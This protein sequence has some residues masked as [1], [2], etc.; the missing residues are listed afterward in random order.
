MEDRASISVV[1]V[2]LD[3]MLFQG[4]VRLVV[5]RGQDGMMHWHLDILLLSCIVPVLLY[6]CSYCFDTV[7]FDNG[8]VMARLFWLSVGLLLLY[9][10][11]C[12]L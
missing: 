9:R 6:C 3:R 7:L 8:S 2:I 5:I 11:T 4:V 10:G 12:F 1:V